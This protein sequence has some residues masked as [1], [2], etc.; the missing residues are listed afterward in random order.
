MSPDPSVSVSASDV[1]WP[2]GSITDDEVGPQRLDS[3]SAGAVS[4]LAVD[5]LVAFMN[6]SSPSWFDDFTVFMPTDRV[7][8]Y[9]NVDPA[10]VPVA[11]V[12]GVPSLSDRS[13]TA[14]VEVL[15]PTD[16]GVWTVIVVNS[17]SVAVPVWQVTRF[18]LPED[19]A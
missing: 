11:V 9:R 6:T 18:V 5:A 14:V 10:R 13:S 19:Q 17:G 1:I 3:V 7:E 16:L 15:V 12:T 8:V 2:N 4:G